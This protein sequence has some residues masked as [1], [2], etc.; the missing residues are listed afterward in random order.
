MIAHPSQKPTLVRQEKQVANLFE[1]YV[2]GLYLFYL[3]PS[4]AYTRADD[5]A[6]SLPDF[7]SAS[8]EATATTSCRTHGQAL[9]LLEQWLHPL[10]IPLADW[11]IIQLREAQKQIGP[12][13]AAG[14]IDNTHDERA[15]GA[16]ARLNQHFIVEEG[17]QPIFQVVEDAPAWTIECR[18]I[19]KDGTV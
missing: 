10:F 17:M 11:A 5:P 1:A 8:N 4:T 15:T 2:A 14:G 16:T 19:K 12:S 13:G 9:D 6:S 7:R 18:A 3:R